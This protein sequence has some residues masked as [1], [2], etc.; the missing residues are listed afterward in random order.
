MVLEGGP[1]RRSSR[2]WSPRS[3]VSRSA[4]RSSRPRP[5]TDAALRASGRGSA[6]L[7][8]RIRRFVRASASQRCSTRLP[9]TSG[10]P[11]GD[12]RGRCPRP[13]HDLPPPAPPAARRR[14]RARYAG[15]ARDRAVGR[16][17][18][19]SSFADIEALAAGAGSTLPHD[20]EPACA[21]AAAIQ[22]GDIASSRFDG[23]R[24]LERRPDTPSGASTRWPGRRSGAL[25]D[26]PQVGQQA[27]GA[28]V[29]EGREMIAPLHSEAGHPGPAVPA[30]RRLRGLPGMAGAEWPLGSMPGAPG[31]RPSEHDDVA[32]ATPRSGWRPSD[33]HHADAR[34]SVE[35][36]DAPAITGLR[37]RPVDLAT[38][39]PGI[40]VVIK[41][42]RGRRQRIR[43]DARRHPPRPRTP[44][45]FRPGP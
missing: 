23:W 15:N 13:A 5:S 22:D 38:D 28:E 6:G 33:D 43:P 42:C 29:R 39:P 14:P 45:P 21:V 10:P 31:S 19:S 12:P 1:R 36:P 24:K 16:R 32:Q 17:G 34:R 8:G 7:D 26:D 20:G 18:G 25:E 37:F 4:F 27:H 3:R 44:A 41:E 9:V 30:L 11:C 40:A 2:T 35:L